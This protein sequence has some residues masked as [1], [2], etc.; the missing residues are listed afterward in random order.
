MKEQHPK[1]DYPANHL[2]GMKV[3]VGGSNC[4][5]CVFV[6]GDDCS[7]AQFV[8]WNFGDHKIPGNINAYCCDFFDVRATTGALLR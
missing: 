5:K 2:V 8:K 4:A 3:P 7:N 6:R 1:V